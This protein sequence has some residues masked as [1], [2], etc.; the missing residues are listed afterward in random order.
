M[1][2]TYDD[3]IREIDARVRDTKRQPREG[4]REKRYIDGSLYVGQTN[5]DLRQGYGVYYYQNGDIYAGD[6]K[7]NKLHGNG[8]Y[9][10]LN[11]EIYEGQVEY[12]M[13]VRYRFRG[14]ARRVSLN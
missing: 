2:K 12:G 4:Y 10:F 6:W 14:G 5:G 8:V 3:Y 13:K 7:D 9:L 11:K 1:R